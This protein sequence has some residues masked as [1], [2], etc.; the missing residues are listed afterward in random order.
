MIQQC[1]GQRTV[2]YLHRTILYLIPPLVVIASVCCGQCMSLLGP[3]D[4]TVSLAQVE[5]GDLSKFQHI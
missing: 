1:T 3:G 5:N 2:N 4:K